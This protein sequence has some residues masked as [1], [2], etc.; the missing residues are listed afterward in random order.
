MLR[1][2]GTLSH[3]AQKVECKS[4]I[5]GSNGGVQAKCARPI[6]QQVN[7]KLQNLL[8]RK[9]NS[10]NCQRPPGSVVRTNVVIFYIPLSPHGHTALPLQQYLRKAPLLGI[11]LWV[12]FLVYPK[13][14]QL[15]SLP[16]KPCIVLVGLPPIALGHLSGGPHLPHEFH[17]SHESLEVFYFFLDTPF[18]VEGYMDSACSPILGARRLA[19]NAVS[20]LQ[21]GTVVPTSLLLRWKLWGR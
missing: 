13:S 5:P 15:L 6:R 20:Q 9:E 16:G 19:G 11:G 12:F 1:R 14:Q 18:N 4:L 10:L 21:M 17:L 7:M 2:L 8:R 3:V